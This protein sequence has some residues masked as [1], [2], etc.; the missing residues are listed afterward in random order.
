MIFTKVTVKRLAVARLG[1]HKQAE[2]KGSSG[3]WK[4][5]VWCHNDICYYT[6]VQTHRMNCKVNHKLWGLQCQYRFILGLKKGA[7][8]VND[9]DNGRG[10]ACVGTGVYGKFLPS[11]Q[12]CCKPPIVQNI[13]LKNKNDSIKI[14]VINY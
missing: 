6:V 10:Y 13:V 2:Y 14:Q 1:W 5:S 7:I 12:L 8:L 3:E 9:V 4:H 11:F